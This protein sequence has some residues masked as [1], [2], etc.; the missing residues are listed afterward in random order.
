LNN[1]IPS[2]SGN[3]PAF[4]LHLGFPHQWHKSCSIWIIYREA[5]GYSSAT[6]LP[7]DVIL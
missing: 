2:H 4:Q 5:S 7:Q 3:A 1:T 6:M